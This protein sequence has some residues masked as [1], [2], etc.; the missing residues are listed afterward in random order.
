VIL[1][2]SLV[3]TFGSFRAV[4]GVSLEVPRGKIVTVL[5]A[6]GAGKSTILHILAGELEP[7]A[8]SFSIGISAA[9]NS[10][11][12][13]VTADIDDSSVFTIAITVA[14]SGRGAPD[15]GIMRARSLRM[16]FSVSSP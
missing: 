13:D 8:G 10:I 4:G 12:A 14:S 2:D 6:N 3:K 11:T 1:V 5:G 9:V 7:D 16:I 15:G